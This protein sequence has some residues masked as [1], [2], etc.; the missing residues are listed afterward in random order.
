MRGEREVLCAAAALLHRMCRMTDWLYAGCFK[1][2]LRRPDM[3]SFA[4]KLSGSVPHSWHNQGHHELIVVELVEGLD[5]L[6]GDDHIVEDQVADQ[7]ILHPPQH[8]GHVLHVIK[9]TP[10][11]N[12]DVL[13]IKLVKGK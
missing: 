3:G 1:S 5:L 8:L 2:L 4:H 10:G 7:P 6:A 13:Q 12:C 11:S 9:D